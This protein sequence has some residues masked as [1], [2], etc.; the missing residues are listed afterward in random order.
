[1]LKNQ[2]Y[3]NIIN[4]SHLNLESTESHLS[5]VLHQLLLQRGI[6]ER[7][8]IESFIFPKLEQLHEPE[9]ISMIEKAA[10]RIHKAIEEREKILVYGDYDADGVSSTALLM[11]VLNELGAECDFYIPNRFTEGYGP[12]EAAFIEAKENGF[13]VIVTVDNGISAHHEATVAKQ[14]GIDL[15]ITD[16]HEIQGELPDA[17]AIIHPKCSESYPFH[18]LAG[19]GVAF[20]FAEYLLGFFPEHL[21]DFVAIGTIADLVPLINENRILA[22]YGLEKLS[23][24]EKPGLIALKKQ[25]EIEGIVTEEDV[26]FLIGPR[27]NA[28]GRLQDADMAVELLLSQDEE[29]ARLL[30]EEIQSINEERQQIVQ[31]IVEEAEAMVDP[32]DQ[33]SVIIVYKE[34]W[35]EGV[36][37]IVASRLVRKYNRP[38]I[39]LNI[40]S[41]T[42]LAKGSA[43]SIPAFDLFNSCM[44]IKHIFTS[45][46]GHA[47]AAGMTLR[48]ENL[49]EL[50]N[51]LNQIIR[52]QL[53]AEDFI[54][55]I[56]INYS[57][58][59]N[60]VN[61]TLIAEIN[62]LAP[63]GMG[64]PKP[65]FQISAQPKEI[66]QIGHL[67]NHLKLQFEHENGIMEA[68][69]FRMGH[70]YPYMTPKTDI[71]IVG[72]LGINEWNGFKKPQMIIE[73]IQISERQ[74][75]DYRGKL[76]REYALFN[77][78]HQRE[79]ALINMG[80]EQKYD[81]PKTMQLVY[82]TSDLTDIH[83]ADALYIYDLPQD[84]STLQ[85]IVNKVNPY[86]IFACFEVEESAYMTP[87]P[88]RE[89]FKW[90]YALIYHRKKL[91]LKIE[92]QRIMAEKQW[93]KQKIWWMSK[94]FFEL[95][96][97]TIEDGVIQLESSPQKRELQTSHTYQQLIARAKIEKTLFY[98]TY[99]GLV[100]WFQSCLPAMQ[101]PKEEMSYGL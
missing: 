30:A 24:T 32:N 14:L 46:G 20:K 4:E 83:E 84:L 34:G 31:Q 69:G 5:P 90:Y 36:L 86:N 67:K 77:K 45:F 25:C 79:L 22:Y 3:W 65:I 68:I 63:F 55:V 56:D 18:E 42:E 64:N 28:V 71:T 57:I 89:D 40:N 58:D 52:E 35:N 49:A 39:V 11:T 16:H 76:I 59:V 27:L 12:N 72:E 47:Q 53:T 6:T 61:E 60:D 33:Q 51:G 1:M 85:T 82:Y 100:A 17:Y 75:F 41:E 93:S 98:S 66:R 8:E 54:P 38:T 48:V 81:I 9:K 2:S 92:H 37:G 73:D 94:V 97:V 15:I 78:Q 50:M 88:T 80:N 95:N 62:Q 29:Q 96:F 101:M 43:R 44:Q 26:G 21:L 19:V 70:L 74:I 13:N 7:E 23:A 10:T 91:D 87:I 99:E